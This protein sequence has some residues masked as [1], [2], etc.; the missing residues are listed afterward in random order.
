[1]PNN[2]PFSA[3]V[4]RGVRYFLAHTP[5]M[6]RRGSKPSRDIL[7]DPGLAP[8]LASHLRS[9]QAATA[10]APNRAFLGA[11]Y[12]D[13]LMQYPPPWYENNGVAARWGPHG[14]IMP[15]EEFYGLLKACDP[16]DLVCLDEEFT[17]VVAATLA[18][19][20]LFTQDDVQKLG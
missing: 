17:N 20:P 9:Y 6:V 12:P 19:H 14:E 5:G 8:T 13:D 18:N 1:M 7:G 4:V 16:F 2:T 3:P 15:E 11:I 10:Y